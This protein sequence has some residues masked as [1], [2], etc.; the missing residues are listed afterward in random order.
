MTFNMIVALL[1]LGLVIVAWWRDPARK[2][3]QRNCESLK[4]LLAHHHNMDT[5][6]EA[7]G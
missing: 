5:H 4:Q 7:G 1:L 2:K 3:M 6:R